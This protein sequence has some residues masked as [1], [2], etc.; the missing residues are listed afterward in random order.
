MCFEALQFK[1]GE[2]LA[3]LRTVFLRSQSVRLS[4][5]WCCLCQLAFEYIRVEGR[6]GGENVWHGTAMGTRSYE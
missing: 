3:S 1:A 5:F 4:G 6:K 2:V